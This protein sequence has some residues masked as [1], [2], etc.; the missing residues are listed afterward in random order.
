MR[1][2]GIHIRKES[3]ERDVQFES[4]EKTGA[5][6]LKLFCRSDFKARAW[7]PPKKKAFTCSDRSFGRC[8]NRNRVKSDK[9]SQI[10]GKESKERDVQF[11]RGKTLTAFSGHKVTV[12]SPCGGKMK[13]GCDRL[14]KHCNEH[15]GE[16]RNSSDI[17]WES[18]EARRKER[19]GRNILPRSLGDTVAVLSL[20]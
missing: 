19:V 16:G 17:D 2:R 8:A 9:S 6:S 13:P 12:W 3:K 14:V 15:R 1:D 11:K 10:E 18:E 20:E 4:Q 5:T 7:S